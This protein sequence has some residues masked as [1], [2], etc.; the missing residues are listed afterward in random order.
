MKLI[1]KTFL[2]TILP[3]FVFAQTQQKEIDSLRAAL[4][5]SADDTLRMVITNNLAFAF[6]ESNS[7]SAI[8][9]YN[10]AAMLADKL[11]L[12]IDE[13]S[14]LDMKG[15]ILST[16]RNYPQSL[17]TF[18]KA[19]KIAEDPA[20]EKNTWHLPKGSTPRSE[21]LEWLG[22][23]NNDMGP[24]YEYTGNFDNE[25]AGYQNAKRIAQSIHNNGLLTYVY[26][27][28]A[29]FYMITNQLDSALFYEKKAEA[30]ITYN[31]GKYGALP[32]NTLGKIYQKKGKLDSSR[33][34][35][36]N[37]IKINQKVNNLSNLGDSYLNISDLYRTEKKSDSSQFF[38]RKAVNTYKKTLRPDGL[39]NAY[40]LLYSIFEA[41]N[42]KDSAFT[43]LKLASSL[44]DSLNNAERKNL[45]AYQNVGFDEQLRL[46]ELQKEKIQTENRIRMYAMLAG[47][48]VVMLIAFLL[49]RNNRNR[50]KANETL[51]KQKEEI[52]L[53]KK[54][55]EQT[56]GELKSTQAQ[57]IHSEKM[58]SLGELTAGIAHEIKNPLNFVNNFSEISNE[59]IN[60][61]TEELQKGNN[62]DALDIAKDL[63]QN[64]EKI[65]HHGKRADSI[66]KGMLLHS[67]GTS[68][69]KTPTGIN[70]ILDEYVNLAYHGMR[71]KDKEFNI[72]IEKD[73]DKSVEKINVVSQDI[74][75]AFLNIINNAC[76]AANEKKKMTGDDFSP[77]IKVST[78]NLNDKVEI[79][80]ADNGNGIPDKIKDKIFQ[81]FFTTKPTGEGTGL[82]L[83]LSY[84]IVTKVHGGELK[85]ET[86]DGEGAEFIIIIP[87]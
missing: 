17:S 48:F 68:G 26:V 4:Q 64:L 87:K 54:N 21:R 66:V 85:V 57:L 12:K 6:T 50:K 13:V 3:V 22:W 67:R 39:V 37:A 14:E 71:A 77:T 72:T 82:G 73:Y 80:I 38:A 15:Y 40:N 27:G 74:S 36:I 62:E 29:H 8:F 35:F 76:Y 75:R 9:Y 69:K 7:D 44:N 49:Y 30:V 70:N 20:S 25:L 84:D 61:M 28:L 32:L 45:L 34:A 52:E 11:G 16:Q 81:P 24:L 83:S 78:K 59:L 55:A 51:Q 79:R 42:N 33:I 86:K 43:Y 41:E 31:G 58:A 63:K 10:K 1:I 56:L 2:A 23:I 47:I 19:K 18:L 5:N 46:E 65:N 60:E 53:Q